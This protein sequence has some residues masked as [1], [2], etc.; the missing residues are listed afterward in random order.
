MYD[1]WK[2]DTWTAKSVRTTYTHDL[3]R[4]P[5][6]TLSLDANTMVQVTQT[7][8]PE[9][10]FQ[11][12]NDLASRAHAAPMTELS[13]EGDDTR[14]ANDDVSIPKLE[15]DSKPPRPHG[16][17]LSPT[18]SESSGPQ[19]PTSGFGYGMV[20]T[21]SVQVIPPH[22]SPHVSKPMHSNPGYMN[23]YYTQPYVSEKG[24]AFWPP[25]SSVSQ[26]GY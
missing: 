23:G 9:A 26:Y 3:I 15:E 13:L 18:T 17:P 19:S 2:R 6:L 8:L 12:G 24:P 7:H 20:M 22:E 16:L 4:P 11:E 1:V 14:D 10:I 21:P 25:T 5:T